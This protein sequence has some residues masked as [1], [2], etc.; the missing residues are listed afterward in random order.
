MTMSAFARTIY[1]RKYSMD[2]KED[3]PD[4]ARRVVSNVVGPYLP[5]LVGPITGL[6]TERKFMPGGRY[7][8]AAGRK[9]PQVNNCFLFRAEDSRQGW[10]WLMN[11]ITQ[12]L[13]TG[14]GIGVVYTPL[15][16]EGAPIAGMG[17][18]ST[19]PC[20]LMQMVNE[21]GRHIMQG[22][23]RRSAIWAG[24]HWNHPDIFK[25]IRLKDWPQIYHDGKADDFN[26]PAPM[27]GTNISVILDDDFFEAYGDPTHRDHCL[28]QD[29]YWAVVRNM[30]R[31][32]EPGF[33][34]DVGEHSGENLRNA[35]VHGDTE[36]LTDTGYTPVRDIVG[37]ETT[38]WT[39]KRWATNVVFKKT[40]EMVPT[41][42]V[43]MTGGREVVCDP[44]HPFLVERWE[45]RGER[46]KLVDI[47]R[48]PA[49]ELE[50]GDTLHVRLPETPPPEKDAKA[51]VLGFV[52]GDGTFYRKDRA[53]VT[54]CTPSKLPCVEDLG[55]LPHTRRVDS[56]G[57]TRIHFSGNHL[58]AGRR[59][60]AVP[61]GESTPWVASFV[62]GL[63]DADGN[64][65]Q[66]QKRIRL[67]SVS[68][69]FLTG[70][71]RMLES[72][73]ILSHVT[74]GGPSGYGGRDSW[75]LVVAAE[76]T[77]TFS[78]IVPTVRVR[79]DLTGYTP[80]R[81]S[82]VK[83]LSV[84]P[85]ADADVYCCDVGVEE[86]SFVAE[87][88]VVSNCT[89]VT[90]ADDDDMCN[91]AS[92][93]LG[94]IRDLTEMKEAVE[95]GTAFLLCGTIY[96]KL[97]LDGMY[98][99]REKNRRLGLG[100]MGLHEWLLKRG[101][102]YG[103]DADLGEWMDVYKMSG[104]FAN[105]Y[106]DKLSISRPVATR[107]VAPNGT[108]SIIGETTSSGEPITYVAMKRRYL[109]GK[110]WKAQYVID[111]TA[112]R[113]VEEGVHPDSI[114]DSVTLSEDVERR[115][116]FQSWLQRYVDHGISSTINLPPWGSAVNNEDGVTRFG[117]TLLHYLP[118]L[119]GITAYPDGS[120][121][122]QP[123]VKVPYDEAIRQVGVEFEDSS[124]SVCKS[125][126]CGV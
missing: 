89:E 39:G 56:R 79:L 16:R 23:S 47:E 7:L 111:P 52:Y 54:V 95:L 59:K 64:A 14:G 20:S 45:G 42:R 34:V 118:S 4:T 94:R 84:T 103:P 77:A 43:T 30:L 65:D 63:F 69:E 19:G 110:T 124:E 123:L 125:G 15:R 41:V 36:V 60:D 31:T 51:Y 116:A 114:E 121:G 120:R 119:R 53:E 107:A 37:T 29:V 75:Q 33:S 25:F 9:F 71:R 12:S 81:K 57:Y 117:K 72:L 48:V 80:Y 97:P 92:L 105:R 11:K 85:D 112:K 61:T 93:N 87:G 28:S 5:D 58:F 82:A 83:V 104:A 113:L 96:S 73:G 50:E 106:A 98:R 10:G 86:H 3:W 90:S 26:F 46:R 40:G 62:A 100:L 6:V 88:V 109:D 91:L 68:R 35:P 44:T 38:V 1:L 13:M 122:G 24:L 55:G 108:I 49:G 22:G 78:E 8:Y 67:S 66:T 2:G 17:G 70:V 101:K 21:S 102:R 18:T 74:K 115:M 99:V 126:V 76:S 32:G 27:D